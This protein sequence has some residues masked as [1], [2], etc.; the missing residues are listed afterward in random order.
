MVL[1]VC[2]GSVGSGVKVRFVDD[3]WL[4]TALKEQPE[5]TPTQICTCTSKNINPGPFTFL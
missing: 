5:P 3:E 1:T 4:Q 2:V